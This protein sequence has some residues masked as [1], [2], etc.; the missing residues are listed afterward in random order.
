MIR[1]Y[2]EV[3]YP[4]FKSFKDNSL[5]VLL[6]RQVFVVSDRCLSNIADLICSLLSS[7]PTHKYHTKDLLKT[8]G[9]CFQVQA[10]NKPLQLTVTET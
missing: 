2:C 3:I 4:L 1:L 6:N 9:S 10:I 5:T 7:H 8:M